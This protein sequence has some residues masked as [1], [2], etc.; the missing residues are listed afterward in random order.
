MAETR[1]PLYYSV[2]PNTKINVINSLNSV[3]GHESYL[4]DELIDVS[5]L[6][7]KQNKTKKTQKNPCKSII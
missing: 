3:I 2:F 1:K 7:E 6:Q 5:F 4:N